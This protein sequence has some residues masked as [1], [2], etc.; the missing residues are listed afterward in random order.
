MGMTGKLSCTVQSQGINK[1]RF[2]PNITSAYIM[3]GKDGHT[4]HI[5]MYMHIVNGSIVIDIIYSP[6]VNVGQAN[7]EQ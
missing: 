4:H 6:R 1:V 3:G 7:E 5:Y 2:Y